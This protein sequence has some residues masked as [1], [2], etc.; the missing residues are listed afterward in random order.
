LNIT[1]C[2][3]FLKA[4]AK[5]L[6]AAPQKG[7]VDLDMVKHAL[8]TTG[9]LLNEIAPE[10]ELGNKLK[11]DFLN[12]LKAK[13]RVLE[14]SGDSL[15]F[16]QANKALTSGNLNFDDLKSLQKDINQAFE[17]IFGGQSGQFISGQPTKTEDY[18]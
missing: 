17:K 4:S 5:A 8:Q 15:L 16:G 14:L 7:F 12:S 9:E 2:L 18:R 11:E 10:L 1:A 6:E 13:L 3:E